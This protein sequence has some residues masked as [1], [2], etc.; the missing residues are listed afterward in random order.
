[1]QIGAPFARAR[2][3]VM[4]DSS[5][6]STTPNDEAKTSRRA[7]LATVAATAAATGLSSVASAQTHASAVPG[8]PRAVGREGATSPSDVPPSGVLAQPPIEVPKQNAPT[9]QQSG[10]PPQPLPPSQRIGFA[11][12]GLGELSIR[13]ILPAFGMCKKARLAAL[14]SGE[15]DKAQTLASEY[16]IGANHVYSYANFDR[17]RDD[18]TVDV[19]YV[20]LP[21]SMHEEYTVRAA[22]AGKH[23]LCEKPM[24]TS[25]ASAT[26]MIQACATANRHLMIAYRIQYEPHNRLAQKML[27]SAQ[28]GKTKIIEAVNGQNQ[29]DPNQWRQKLALAGGGSLPD[30]GLYCLNTSRFLLGEEPIEVMASTYSTPGDPRFREVEENCLWQMRFPSGAQA[31]CSTSYGHH[32]TRRYRVLAERGVFGLDPAFSYSGLKMQVSFAQ[33]RIERTEEPRLMERNQ[34]ALEMD[35]M[36]E[37]VLENKR[38]YTPGEEGLQDHRIMEAIYQSARERRAVS[39]LSV[40]GFD[41]FRGTAPRES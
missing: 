22:R 18:P 29:G 16:G 1:M 13:E 3:F 28:F 7:F 15:P 37:C 21:N 25:S 33:N 19:V 38:P 30:V 11:I 41:A 36:A 10:P 12:V 26:R 6:D 35:H 9:E 27:R 14:V 32:E 5:F 4:S 17:L 2:R 20:V 31:N 40:A 34:F 24:T 39:L 23:V 8:V